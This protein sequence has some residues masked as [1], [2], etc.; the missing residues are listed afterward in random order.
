MFVN[1]CVNVSTSFID[2]L[3]NVSTIL[4][5]GFLQGRPPP[6]KKTL[7]QPYSA[8]IRHMF[9]QDKEFWGDHGF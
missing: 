5:T 9:W 2:I 6:Q 3:L 7:K 4:S 1:T 8:S